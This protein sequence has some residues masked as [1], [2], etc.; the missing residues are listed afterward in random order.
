MM[1]GFGGME[2]QRKLG[3]RT[4]ARRRGH[5]DR[6]RTDTLSGSVHTTHGCSTNIVSNV[7]DN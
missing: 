2:G 1:V 3:A 5:Y 4:S 7:V 6:R